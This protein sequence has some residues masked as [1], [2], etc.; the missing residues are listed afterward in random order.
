APLLSAGHETFRDFTKMVSAFYHDLALKFKKV[1][2]LKDCSEA[3]LYRRV[4]MMLNIV[5]RAINIHLKFPLFDDDTKLTNYL[6][7]VVETTFEACA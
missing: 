4:V 2:R 3:D 5:D 7:R 1:D 6:L